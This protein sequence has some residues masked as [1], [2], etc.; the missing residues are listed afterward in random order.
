M[1]DLGKYQCLEEPALFG[2][3]KPYTI[4]LIDKA[5]CKKVKSYKRLIDDDNNKIAGSWDLHQVFDGLNTQ[6]GPSIA[7]LVIKPIDVADNVTQLP[8][9]SRRRRVN[10][11]IKFLT[12]ETKALIVPRLKTG[13]EVHG[14]DD[15]YFIKTS[16]LVS[17]HTTFVRCLNWKADVTEK[18]WRDHQHLLESV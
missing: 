16:V 11:Q 5:Y 6:E 10:L 2:A 3:V 9:G 8:D 1:S 4:H 18:R 17:D 15:D 14:G 13:Y 12:E 7:T